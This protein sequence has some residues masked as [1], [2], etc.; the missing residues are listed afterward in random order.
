MPDF[1]FPRTMRLVNKPQFDRVFARRCSAADQ[2]LIVLV[3]ENELG[4]RRLGLVVSRKF[5]NAVARN[6]FKRVIREAFRQDQAKLPP[7]VDLVV[8]PKPSARDQDRRLADALIG[9][10]RRAARKL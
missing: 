10:A 1:R 2:R 5:G 3:C 4:Q 8:L 6:R 7:S 9:L